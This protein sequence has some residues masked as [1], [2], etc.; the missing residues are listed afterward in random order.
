MKDLC[1]LVY[2]IIFILCGS[3]SYAVASPW[4]RTGGESFLYVSATN[5]QSTSFWDKD[6]NLVPSCHA[7]DRSTYLH[8]EYGHSYYNTLFAATSIEYN[9]CGDKLSR[10]IPDLEVGIR[11][12]LN[13]FRN[14]RTWELSAIVPVQGDANDPTTP[15]TGEL[16]VRAGLYFLFLPDPYEN[17]YERLKGSKWSLDLR[18]TYWTGD[19]AQEIEGRVGWKHQ[20]FDTRW[21]FKANIKG[22]HS[23]GGREDADFDPENRFRSI[24][25][26]KISIRFIL[27]APL[28]EHFSVSLGLGQDIW[29]RNTSKNTDL[30]LSISRHWK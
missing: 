9:S 13:L 7:N 16:G 17:P 6:R 25:E 4:M 15:G 23:F 28:T 29:G 2:F 1:R 18:A 3:G 12:R 10:G 14:G 8:Y 30:R 19:A 22:L 5:T 26:D 20:I 11:R 21:R 24:D 27:S